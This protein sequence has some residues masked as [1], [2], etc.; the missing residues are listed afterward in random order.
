MWKAGLRVTEASYLRA[1]DIDLEN[2]LINLNAEGNT[3][4]TKGGRP[5]VVEYQA[6]IF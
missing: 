6:G 2:H 1:Q 5:R 4:R 3:N